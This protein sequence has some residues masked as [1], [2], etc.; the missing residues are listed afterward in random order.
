MSGVLKWNVDLEVGVSEGEDF[1]GPDRGAVG[2]F[3]GPGKFVRAGLGGS[4]GLGCC[5]SPRG[6]WLGSPEA[7]CSR[8]TSVRWAGTRF[9]SDLHAQVMLEMQ[10]RHGSRTGTVFASSP[11]L[12]LF[13]SV[14]SDD[15]F[16]PARLD[17]RR[18]QELLRLS[19]EASIL[20]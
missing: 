16:S 1:G 7:C 11:D 14:Y 20:Q 3:G 2:L 8:R 10:N 18:Q 19:C 5:G 13:R 17:P 15:Y 9:Q 6:R 4:E 12:T